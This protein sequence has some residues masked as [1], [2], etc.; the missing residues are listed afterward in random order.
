M[1]RRDEYRDKLSGHLT[2]VE[3]LPI[4]DIQPHESSTECA[5][6]PS[7]TAEGATKKLI[8][9]SFDGREFSEPDYQEVGQ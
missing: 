4:V 5:C 3:V 9:N 8:H 2:H 7:L 1:W 6:I